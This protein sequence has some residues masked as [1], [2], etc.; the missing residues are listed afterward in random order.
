MYEI[1]RYLHALAMIG[2]VSAAIVPPA[3]LLAVTRRGDVGAM[4]GFASLAVSLR[5]LAAPLIVLAALLGFVAAIIGRVDP[6]RPWLIAAYAAF[7]IALLTGALLSDP[8]ARRV[9]DAAGA[10]PANAPSRELRSAIDDRRG[11]LAT[12]ILAISVAIII[13]M[14]VKRP[15]G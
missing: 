2:A 8:W 4:R 13:F 7:A 12:A 1:I 9:G 14:G 11:A 10:S 5:S 6:L 3:L 15:G